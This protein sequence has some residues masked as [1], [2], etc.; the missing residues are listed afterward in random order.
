MAFAQGAVFKGMALLGIQARVFGDRCQ[1]R[2]QGKVAVDE[3]QNGGLDPVR[4]F[5]GFLFLSGVG[6]CGADKG[7][8][9]GAL[10]IFPLG[11]NGKGLGRLVLS[12]RVQV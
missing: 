2:M 5:P 11:C 12:R 3:A 7:G 6:R 1:N 8:A 9:Y 10:A 4:E